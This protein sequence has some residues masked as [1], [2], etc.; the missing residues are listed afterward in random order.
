MDDGKLKNSTL[1][2][3]KYDDIAKFLYYNG[4]AEKI[5]WVQP[6]QSRLF[7]EIEGR[8]VIF[9]RIQ[10]IGFLENIKT[11]ADLG[12]RTFVGGLG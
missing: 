2:K 11:G 12:N 9:L 6:P 4:A 1:V 7:V 3:P 10:E 5:R 8:K